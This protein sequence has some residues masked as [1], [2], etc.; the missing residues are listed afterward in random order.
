[1]ADVDSNRYTD[2]SPEWH[3]VQKSY[4]TLSASY[5]VGNGDS[6]LGTK[7]PGREP[8]HPLFEYLVPRSRM[9]IT[10]PTRPIYTISLL[11]TVALLSIVSIASVNFGGGGY[12]S[13]T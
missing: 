9:H 6:V 4:G 3:C 11:G 13:S 5:P 8:Y 1:M 7:K 2:L 10:L 12:D